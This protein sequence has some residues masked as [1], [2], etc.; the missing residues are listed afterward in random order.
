MLM[1]LF[2][3]GASGAALYTSLL[4]LLR[5]QG[6]TKAFAGITL[7]NAGSV[8]VHESVGFERVAVYQK[9]GYKL[10]AWRDVGWWQV[11]LRGGDGEPA[12]PV[13]I[14]PIQGTHAAVSALQKGEEFLKFS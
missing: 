13:P 14:G 4:E 8:G 7:P 3:G 9:V 10:G 1:Q 2:A 5:Q 11:D 12:E 6:Y